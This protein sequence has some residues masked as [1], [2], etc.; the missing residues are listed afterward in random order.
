MFSRNSLQTD[1]FPRTISFNIPICVFLFERTFLIIKTFYVFLFSIAIPFTFLLTYILICFNWLWDISR[2]L[3]SILT[4][5]LSWLVTL[6]LGI[7]LGTLTTH[8]TLFEIAD[9][10]HVELSKPTEFFPT[11]YSNNFQDSNSVLNL[12]F[13]HPNF[14]EHNNNCIH[15]E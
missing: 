13:L 14:I 1:T 2:I 5:S 7:V 11:R 12:V 8:I 4:M 6:I 9:P 10:F 15:L 3:K